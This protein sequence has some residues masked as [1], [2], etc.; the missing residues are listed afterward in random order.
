[1]KNSSIERQIVLP[2]SKALEISIRSIRVRFARS[3]LAAAGII[4]A[5]AFLMN[6]WSSGIIIEGLR[7]VQDRDEDLQALLFKQGELSNAEASKQRGVWLVSL[8]LLVC[9]VGIANAVLMSV[10]ER[11]REIGTMKCLG[12]LDSFILKLF[13]L[14]SIFL[15]GLGT[16]IGVLMGLFLAALVKLFTYGFVIFSATAWVEVLA[17]G[18]I[19][20]AIGTGLSIVGALYPAHRAARMQ[21]VEAMRVTQ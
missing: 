10:T 19:A 20:F 4:L 17:R 6:V 2:L 8:S 12:A 13:L 7:Q 5:T 16:I 11:Y 9:V 18:G 3:L 14:E 1:M 15:G 21:P